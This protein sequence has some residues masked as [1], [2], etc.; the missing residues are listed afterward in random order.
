MA[1]MSSLP[2]HQWRGVY[3]TGSVNH[4][5]GRV[6]SP[7]PSRNTSVVTANF[8]D[9]GQTITGDMHQSDACIPP[10]KL[11]FFVCFRQQPLSNHERA[12]RLCAHVIDLTS[13]TNDF[14]FTSNVQNLQNDN[15]SLSRLSSWSLET[16]PPAT[17]NNVFN[18]LLDVGRRAAAATAP[19]N[20]TLH[21]ETITFL[22][23]DRQL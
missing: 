1:A 15:R 12:Q 14:N 9:N 6:H 16:G 8:T 19:Q 20:N 13:G 22:R 10:H 7:E 4:S 23:R 11:L 5:V 17:G 21:K 2:V 3:F 18:Q